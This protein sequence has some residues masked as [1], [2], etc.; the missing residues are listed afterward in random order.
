MENRDLVK[1]LRDTAAVSGVSRVL[2]ASVGVAWHSVM[3]PGV[4]G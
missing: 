2:D 4:D 1:R 3:A